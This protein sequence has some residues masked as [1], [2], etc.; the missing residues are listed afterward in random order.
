MLC[1]LLLVLHS[2]QYPRR[3]LGLC[4]KS[5]HT[6]GLLPELLMDSSDGLRL[7]SLS[8]LPILC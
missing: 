5:H 6:R 1:Y 8:N 2:L 7:V 4:E 3:F